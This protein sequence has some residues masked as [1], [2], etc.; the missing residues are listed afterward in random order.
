MINR[1]AIVLIGLTTASLAAQQPV[2][3][4]RIEV[5]PSAPMLNVG[6]TTTLRAVAYDG[7]GNRLNIPLL[8]VSAQRRRVTVDSVGF[9]KAH[10]PGVTRIIVMPFVPGNSARAVATVTVRRP[11]I[12]TVQI[13]GAP[14]V[15]FAGATVRHRVRVV[16]AVGVVQYNL[17]ATWASDNEA[18][19]RV[20]RFGD[21]IGVKPGSATLSV[22]VSG[23]T[24]TRPVNVRANPARTLTLTA[25]ADSGRMGDVIQFQARAKDAAGHVVEDLPITYAVKAAVEDTVIAPGAA[26]L[27]E[28]DGR[29]VAQRAGEYTIL[30]SAGDL[31]ARRTVVITHRY[32]SARLPT[33]LGHGVV[34]DVNTSDLWVWSGSDNHDYAI[35]GT[36]N[37]RGIAY[38][39]DVTSPASPTLI[40]SVQVDARTVNDVKV[41]PKRGIC[42]ISRE[43]ASTRRNG[44]VVLD[45]SNPRDVKI[46]SSFDDNLVGGV[47]NVFIWNQHVFSTNS[48][49]RYD[50]I[51]IEDPRAPKRVGFFEID[52]PGHA[53]HDVWVVDGIAYTSNW[54]DGVVMHDVGGGGK[55]GSVS[56]PIKIGQ[57]KYPNRST[58]A[59]FPY[60]SKSTGKFYLF[61]GDEQFPYGLE[62]SGPVEAGGYVHVVDFTDLDHPKEIARY[63][64]PEA[65]PHNLWVENDTL[66]VAYYNAGL[67]VVDV[68]G[69]L[70]GNLYEQG[71]ELARF[72]A[73]D[74][75]GFVAN[76]P[77]AW[78]P[79]PFKGNV[80]FSDMNSGLWAVKLPERPKPLVP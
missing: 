73:K 11:A 42:V 74:P 27:I 10:W 45:C 25:S 6:D 21:V 56:N 49:R 63:Q 57:Y 28:S 69:E 33:A 67:R 79:Q 47:H 72:E 14:G 35:T 46:L 41:D 44:F 39:W 61:L 58:H 43:G 48:G 40:D 16:D 71:R 60:R 37:G 2:K 64:I 9:I 24:T 23:L 1:V 52:T 54:Q 26:G 78:G 36:W 31:V 32:Q 77:M 80:F 3:I 29:F 76:A 50:I 75:K 53:T 8:F 5:E 7:A 19:M 66:Y 34:R 55:G 38:F 13:L 62:T 68:S 51:S 18:V 65:G 12:D 30:A 22:T 20:G 17:P 15:Y 70:M 59:A 4:S